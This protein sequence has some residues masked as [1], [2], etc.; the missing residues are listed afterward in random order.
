LERILYLK[1]NLKKYQQKKGFRINKRKLGSRH[2]GSGQATH[3]IFKDYH[4]KSV[5]FQA[6]NLHFHTPK[7]PSKASLNSMVDFVL[8]GSFSWKKYLFK[9]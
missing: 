8:E 6:L 1:I 4:P 5:C 9:L 7:C 3:L 2:L